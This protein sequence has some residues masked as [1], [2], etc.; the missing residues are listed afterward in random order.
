MIEVLVGILITTLFIGISM[1]FMVLSSL[2]KARSQQYSEAMSWIQEDL[3]D[4]KYQASKYKLSSL[5]NV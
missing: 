5:D 4:I 1:Q 3:E 2:L